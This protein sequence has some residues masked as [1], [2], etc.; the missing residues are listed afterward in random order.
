MAG[1]AEWDLLGLGGLRDPGRQR[2]LGTHPEKDVWKS[3]F[4]FLGGDTGLVGGGN[5]TEIRAGAIPIPHTTKWDPRLVPRSPYNGLG[6]KG[7]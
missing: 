4:V 1:A 5:D 2:C 3:C 7:P 6:G